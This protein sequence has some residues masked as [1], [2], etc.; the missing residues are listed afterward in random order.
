VKIKVPKAIIGS[1][2]HVFHLAGNGKKNLLLM[3]KVKDAKCL[4]SYI[5]H[6]AISVVYNPEHK[7]FGKYVIIGPKRYYALIIL[8]KT[9]ALHLIHIQR[10]EI[11]SPKHIPLV[12]KH[13]PQKKGL[14][15]LKAKPYYFEYLI[16]EIITV[17]S[18]NIFNKLIK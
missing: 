7:R 14:T 4:S 16:V 1:W 5:G 2:K 9:S 11:K 15:Y 6:H 13:N 12:C 18:F 3:N 10:V 8:D 17:L